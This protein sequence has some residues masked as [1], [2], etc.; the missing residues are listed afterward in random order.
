MNTLTFF[1]LHSI[2]CRSAICF[3]YGCR[4]FWRFCGE[5]LRLTM[6]TRNLFFL[7][8]A[9]GRFATWSIVFKASSTVISSHFDPHP[10]GWNCSI[11]SC[12]FVVSAMLT[13]PCRISF[14]TVLCFFSLSTSMTLSFKNV[15]CFLCWVQ[16][17]PHAVLMARASVR[18][19]LTPLIRLSWFYPSVQLSFC[20]QVR[21]QL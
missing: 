9:F 11:V 2:F 8:I 18:L 5:S 6:E 17:R 21:T 15:L 14:W 20:I 12:Q 1:P 10:I 7:E 4:I 3:L 16:L 19:L 13:V